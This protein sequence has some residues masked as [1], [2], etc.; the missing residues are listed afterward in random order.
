MRSSP[1]RL[2]V[3]PY[4]Q[5]PLERA[6]AI[7]DRLH[8]DPAREHR[9]LIAGLLSRPASI[10]PKYF[11]DAAGCA[12]FAKICGLPEYYPTRTEASIFERYRE[13]I[14]GAI[15][16]GKQ[17][18]DLGAGDC[19]KGAGWVPWLAPSRYVAVDIAGDVLAEAM[20]RLSNVYPNLETRGIVTDFTR[21]LDLRDDVDGGATLFFYPGSSIGNF[22]PSDALQFLRSIRR[23]CESDP[24]SGLLIGVDTK[25]D[26]ARLQAAYDDAA[27]VTAAFNRNV[28]LHVNRI[29][30]TAF[31]P[32]SFD[33]VALYDVD[34][35][36]IEMHLQARIS[37]TVRIDSIARTFEVGERI[38]TESSYKYTPVEFTALLQ[39][40]GFR[41]VKCWQD[42]ARDFAVY[43]AR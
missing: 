41:S 3:R 1:V 29:L 11:Y 36:R 13:E 14:A 8:V 12:L 34:A 20:E 26:P 37:Q 43:V 25:K 18:V 39:H 5:P 35:G 22:T 42:D 19:R 23:H 7:V 24:E 6:S 27:S 9:A 32:S 21:G 15:G 10:A 28:L 33:H 4:P 30:G 17:F 38:H 2:Q 16:T 31:V 40:A